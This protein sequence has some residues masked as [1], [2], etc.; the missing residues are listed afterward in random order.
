MLQKSPFMKLSHRFAKLWKLF[1]CF[2]ESG[3]TLKRGEIFNGG[4][5]NER[6]NLDSWGLLPQA[7]R[8]HSV[9]GLAKHSNYR[10]DG[11]RA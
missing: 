9:I 10:T 2:S 5:R 4:A 11:S 8:A 1:A 7:G 3:R 6:A